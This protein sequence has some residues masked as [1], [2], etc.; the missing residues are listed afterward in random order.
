MSD[1]LKVRLWLN[2]TGWGQEWLDDHPYI[3]EMLAKYAAYATAGL[4][5]ENKRLAEALDKQQHILLL[6]C[7]DLYPKA[8]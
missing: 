3:L 1:E 5:Q 4:E 6:E 8:R 2:G 7:N